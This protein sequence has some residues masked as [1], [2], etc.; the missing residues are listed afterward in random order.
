IAVFV[1]LPDGVEGPDRR[2]MGRKIRPA[3]PLLLQRDQN[4]P[5]SPGQPTQC[6]GRLLRRALTCRLEQ[7]AMKYAEL[8][9]VGRVPELASVP[10]IAV[11]MASKLEGRGAVFV[12]QA[13]VKRPLE[14]R[15]QRARAR[16]EASALRCVVRRSAR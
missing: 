10:D 14:R 16:R 9:K 1:S 15:T 8:E 12:A 2:P 4:R 11:V 7:R 5:Q 6:L 13:E 3:P